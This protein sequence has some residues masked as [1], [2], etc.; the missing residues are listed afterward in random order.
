MINVSRFLITGWCRSSS[1]TSCRVQGD[2]RSAEHSLTTLVKWSNRSYLALRSLPIDLPSIFTFTD[3]HLTRYSRSRKMH[4]AH[5]ISILP[6]LLRRARDDH[7]HFKLLISFLASSTLTFTYIECSLLEIPAARMAVASSCW[8][9]FINNI[10][11]LV[12]TERRTL[13]DNLHN[14]KCSLLEIPARNLAFT[15]SWCVSGN[16][17]GQKHT[18]SYNLAITSATCWYFN[19][20]LIVTTERN[21]LTFLLSAPFW[22]FLREWQLLHHIGVFSGN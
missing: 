9:L 5:F 6:Q 20:H 14:L 8:C 22:R 11:L 13:A 2:R 17:Q 1:S 19:K 15:S 10:F 12:T 3:S 21:T 18:T 7:H 4:L 16:R